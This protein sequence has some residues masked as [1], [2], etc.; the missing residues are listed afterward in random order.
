MVTETPANNRKK[1]N[2]TSTASGK[3]TTKHRNRKGKGA[4]VDPRMGKLP[5]PTQQMEAVEE[6]TTDNDDAKLSRKMPSEPTQQ[7]KK[8]LFASKEMIV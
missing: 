6:G 4:D 8:T 5:E 3:A 1:R 7:M 2:K